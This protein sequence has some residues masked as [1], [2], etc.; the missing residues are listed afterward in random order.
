MRTA[1]IS[2]GRWAMRTW[3]ITAPF[4]CARPVMSSTVHALAFEMRRHADQRADRD[5]AGAADAGD[6]NAV[7]LGDV[8]GSAVGGSGGS[9]SSA[10]I[11]GLRASGSAPP[12]DGDEARAEALEAG[13]ILV[14]ARLVDGAL[15][16]E[17]GLDRLHRDAVRLLRAIAAALAHQLVDEDALAAGRE[18][19]RACA[20]GV[21]RRRRSGRRR[22][23]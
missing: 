15:A 1:W 23:R 18:S 4:F 9:S 12:C 14:A 3:L 21:S 8:R 22:S 11:A 20:G 2:S 6:Q 17:L 7:G 5:D 13:E 19:G 10:E 16:A